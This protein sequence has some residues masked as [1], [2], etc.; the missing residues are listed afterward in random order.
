MDLPYTQRIELTL[1][2]DAELLKVARQFESYITGETLA[3]AVA[4]AASQ[5]RDAATVNV[6]GK[7][8]QISVKPVG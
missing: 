8:L 4:T 5:T 2:G 1:A 6:D 3:D 7:A